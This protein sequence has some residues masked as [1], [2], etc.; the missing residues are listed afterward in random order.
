MTFL[1][2]AN[3]QRAT[4]CTWFW[5]FVSILKEHSTVRAHKHR[6]IYMLLPCHRESRTGQ[7]GHGLYT[8]HLPLSLLL[9]SSC[10]GQED[11]VRD[12]YC[13]AIDIMYLYVWTVCI[14]TKHSV[15]CKQQVWYGVIS[16]LKFTWLICNPHCSSV[17][18]FCTAYVLRYTV[19]MERDITGHSSGSACSLECLRPTRKCTIY[20][21]FTAF[22]RQM[23]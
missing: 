9:T 1:A 8:I 15:L 4:T 13:L 3:K 18:T 21:A 12:M 17:N 6:H 5:E 7:L 20:S 23:N 14:D 10:E 2:H 19:V 22:H 11:W 16:H